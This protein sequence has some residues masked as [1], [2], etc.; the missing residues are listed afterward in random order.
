MLAEEM[1][2]GYKANPAIFVSADVA[3]LE[4]A[5]IEYETA[6]LLALCWQSR[7]ASW[8]ER[9]DTALDDVKTVMK[10]QLAKSQIDTTGASISLK[11]IGSGPKAKPRR[12]LP[13]GMPQHLTIL[14]E[15][16]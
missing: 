1:I 16:K 5:L 6:R 2:A 8:T 4:S 3:T 11:L 15:G 7:A 10:L 13:P 14:H 9:K 12:L